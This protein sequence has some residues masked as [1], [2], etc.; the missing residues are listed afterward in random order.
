MEIMMA[1]RTALQTALLDAVF[2]PRCAGCGDFC[3]A[4]FCHDCQSTL[5]PIIA[6]FCRRCGFPF[7]PLSHPAPECA[8]CR[9]NRYHSAPP[10]E[11]LRSIYTFEGALRSAVH[12]LKYR[13]RIALAAPLASLLTEFLR[14]EPAIAQNEL[15]L[16][17]P[18]PLHPWRRWR[19][20]FNQSELLARELAKDLNAQQGEVLKRTRHTPPQ[21]GLSAKQ[22]HE[23]VTGAFAIDE[24]ALQTLN[25]ALG[26]VL[27]IDD[28]C[29]T[30]AT[31][32][33]CAK[34][35]KSAGVSEVYALTLARQL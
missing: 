18:V 14:N 6:P 19:R 16:I 2:P 12:S 27:L 20:G 24:R 31:L 34:A 3:P 25:P 22:R 10:F 35:L 7:D 13:G 33:E 1:L 4:L 8:N 23:N 15:S 30:G 5:R 9:D 32:R 21:V 29:T 26:P 28:V 11:A 17:A